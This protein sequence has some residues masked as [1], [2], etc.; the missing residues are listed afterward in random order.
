[1]A[2]I[3]PGAGVMY[4]ALTLH[5]LWTLGA[6]LVITRQ[7]RIP[8]SA[9]VWLALVFLLPVAGTLLY[10]LA[11]YRRAT[12]PPEPG[13]YRGDAVEQ[14]VACGCGT[15]PAPRNSVELLHNG[16][17][18]FTALIAALQHAVRSIH[19]EYYIIRDDRIGRTIAEILIRKARAGLEVRV[20]YDAVGSWRLSRTTLRRMHEAGVCTAAFEPVRFPWFTTRVSRRNHRKIVVTDGRVAFLGGINIAKYYLDGD[21]MGKWR[22]E[23]LRIEGDAVK[24]L[25]RLFI[26]DWAR[27]TD[28]CLDPRRYVAPHGIRQRLPIQLVLPYHFC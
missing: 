19:M 4:I 7:Q 3:M 11:G 10:V 24:D 25:Q 8:A 16:N 22:D 26:A 23:H 18:A 21:Y 1:M 12:P 5:L 28:E 13:D 2:R 27:V 6:A 17:N 15:R 20:I 9:A 14:I